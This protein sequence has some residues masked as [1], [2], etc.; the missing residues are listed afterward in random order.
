MAK[1]DIA[2]AYRIVP[3]HPDDCPLQAVQWR[4]NTYIDTMLPF[5]L[6]SAVADALTWHPDVEHYLDDFILLGPPGTS[7]CLEYLHRL[8]AEC[9]L[10]GIPLAAEGPTTCLTFLGIE[11]DSEA[12]QL[13]STARPRPP[14]PRVEASYHIHIDSSFFLKVPMADPL[15]SQVHL[16][17]L[18]L[19]LDQQADWRSPVWRAQFSFIFNKV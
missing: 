12:A 13:A 4:G 2:S 7:H 19:L 17:L 14:P 15:P 3:V 16:P 8:E 5:G 6:R 9:H 18:D 1:T 11:I 10:L